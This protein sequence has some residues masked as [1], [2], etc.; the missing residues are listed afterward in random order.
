MRF[1][2]A[3]GGFCDELA[4]GR[5]DDVDGV[6]EL[7]TDVEKAVG[8]KKRLMRAKRLAEVDGGGEFALLEVDDVGGSAVRPG[9]ADARVAVDGNVGEARGRRD[10]DF[11]AVEADGNLGARA[12]GV[13][14]AEEDGLFLLVGGV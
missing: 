9:P 10:G 6:G 12:T 8:A 11:V 13:G 7:R 3:R 2:L 4:R 14:V 5:V 1:G